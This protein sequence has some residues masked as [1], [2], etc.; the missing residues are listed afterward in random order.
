MVKIGSYNE[1][2][3][4]RVVDFGLYLNPKPDEVLLPSKYVPENARPGD[5]LRVFVYTDSEDR[6]VATTRAPKAV[7]GQFACLRVKDVASFGAFMDWG[8]EKDLLVPAGEQQERMKAGRKYVVKVCLDETSGRVYGTS[9][10]SRV[11]DPAPDDLPV[12][13]KVHLLICGITKTGVSAV[14]DNRYAGMLFRGETYMQLS[15]GEI[16]E[17]YVSR[18]REDGKIDLAL[19][20]PGYR[21][22]AD[23]GARIMEIL[24]ER[25][26]FI[27]CHDKSNPEE[28]KRIFSMSKKEFKRAVGGLYKAGRIELTEKGIREKPACRS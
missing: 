5:V 26:G 8:L 17:G 2:V 12:G 14:V 25:G 19:K 15:I 4:E 24:R 18:V 28:I 16:I 22:I 3:V 20:K 1:L 7:V 27:P 9:R 21:S 23:S 13:Q 11:C 10:I 6:P